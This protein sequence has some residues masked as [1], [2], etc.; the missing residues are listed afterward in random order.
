MQVIQRQPLDT[1]GS[2]NA[3]QNLQNM[4]NSKR[5]AEAKAAQIK[6]YS[7]NLKLQAKQADDE[8]EKTKLLHKAA[9]WDS[10]AKVLGDSIKSA[11]PQGYIMSYAGMFPEM[12]EEV[13]GEEEF[14][15][16]ISGVKP[17]GTDAYMNTLAE[18][19]TNQ[20][21]VGAVGGNGAMGGGGPVLSSIG[22]Q[23]PTFDFPEAKTAMT[24]AAEAGKPYSDVEASSIS[25]AD[26][27]EP[28]A[29]DLLS[30]LAEPGKLTEGP[31][32]ALTGRSQRIMSYGESSNPLAGGNP[33]AWA[34]RWVTGGKA[35]E[36]GNA[37][38]KLKNVAFNFG[39]KTLSATE[40]ATVM[41]LLSP[42]DKTEDKWISDI[43]QLVSYLLEKKRLMTQPRGQTASEDAAWEALQAMRNQS[44]T[45]GGV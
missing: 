12:M 45:G 23:G 9:R 10:F 42:V 30:I 31:L 20:S 14:K 16:R 24:A 13:G 1:S 26:L 33:L 39:G 4:V 35:R 34:E 43:K 21:R 11:D 2:A 19:A 41:S 36:A 7:D 27:L 15:K 18:Q 6:Y 32:A 3:A 17:G 40:R 25:Q 44:R 29:N 5:E 22:P 37:L 28:A 8:V 38:A